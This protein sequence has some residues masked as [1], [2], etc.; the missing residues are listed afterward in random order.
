MDP[1]TREELLPV[2]VPVIVYWITSGIYH[3]FVNSKE[4]YRL[5]SKEEEATQNL[6]TPRQVLVGVLKNHTMQMI[7]ATFQFMVRLIIPFISYL[8]SF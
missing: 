6:A 4:E 2:F 3:V 1:E 7:L 8:F 5:Y